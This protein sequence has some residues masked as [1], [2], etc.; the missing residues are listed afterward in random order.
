MVYK[1]SFV[2]RKEKNTKR[3]ESENKI[4]NY[5]RE[6]PS[7]IKVKIYLF[8][9]ALNFSFNWTK[10]VFGIYLFIASMCFFKKWI[11]IS[12]FQLLLI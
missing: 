8:L 10:E 4:C 11:H 7:K 5:K 12:E 1:S 6:K 2:V 3:Y 9:R